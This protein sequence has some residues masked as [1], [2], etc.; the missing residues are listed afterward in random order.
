MLLSSVSF[1]KS[2]CVLLTTWSSSLHSDSDAVIDPSVWQCDGYWSSLLR[3]KAKTT[4]CGLLLVKLP[5]ILKWNNWGSPG[6]ENEER[7][8]KERSPVFHFPPHI[9]S[10]ATDATDSYSPKSISYHSTF[11]LTDRRHRLYSNQPDVTIQRLILLTESITFGQTN[12]M[13]PFN[14]WSYWPNA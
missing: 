11:G 7:A 1:R 14:I 10:F 9:I 13:S 4:S 5:V 6:K 8:R 12:P 3:R 2:V